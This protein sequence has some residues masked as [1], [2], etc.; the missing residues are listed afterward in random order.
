MVL[1]PQWFGLGEGNQ[2]AMEAMKWSFV[3]VG[4]WW[5][6]FSQYT[7]YYLP[8]GRRNKQGVSKKILLNGFQELKKVS[9]S[10]SKDLRL[11]RYLTAFFVYSMAVQTVMLVATY[12]GE[13]EIA[14]GGTQEKTIGL[15]SVL[16]LFKFGRVVGPFGL[17]LA[18][19]DSG[20]FRV[21]FVFIFIGLS[22]VFLASFFETPPQ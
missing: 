21:W 16:R 10:L 11:K 7:F 22:F 1:N 4:I 17:P 2:A 9:E 13:Q 6:L 12:F 18:R 14:W 15:I 20:N 19:E 8:K 5:I 3:S